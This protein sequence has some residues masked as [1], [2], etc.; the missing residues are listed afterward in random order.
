MNG[1]VIG[2]MMAQQA[3]RVLIEWM[4]DPRFRQR[5]RSCLPLVSPAAPLF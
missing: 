5:N 2:I 3:I 4:Q 1:F